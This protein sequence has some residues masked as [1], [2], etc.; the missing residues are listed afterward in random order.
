MAFFDR[1][2][3]ATATTGTGA[4][5]LGSAAAGFRS[6]SG[7]SVPDGAAVSYVIEEGSAWEVGTGTYTASGTSMSRSLIASST[8]SLLNLA[9]AAI[10][11]LTPLAK[12]LVLRLTGSL[13]GKPTNSFVQPLG[14]APR[15]FSVTQANCS[16][17]A[18][19]AA[20]ASTVVTLKK[21][22]TGGTETTVG[23]WTWSAAGTL[24]TVSISAASIAAGD[25]LFV[26]YP[27]TADATLADIAFL[28]S[29]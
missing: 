21:R 29:E 8:G 7:A 3:M 11:S 2:R 20:T 10:V 15:A 5:T 12:D 27:S 19:A 25:Q 17:I 16:G 13:A 26:A 9:G 6:F 1:V 4:I 22:T 28:V 18:R 14:I 24:A 23:T